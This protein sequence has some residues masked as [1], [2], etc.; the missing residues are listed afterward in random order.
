[1]LKDFDGIIV[2][3]GF[4]SR[5]IEGIVMTA[6]Y[7]R[8]NK[9]PYLGLCYGMQI[10]TIEF[11]R[12]VAK[13]PKANTQEIDPK[14][15]DPVIHIMD[16]QKDKVKKKEYGGSMR[17]GVYDCKLQK[18]TKAYEAY[19][20]EDIFERHRH[21]YEFNNDYRARF[22]KLGLVISGVNPQRNLVEIIELRNHPFF[23]GVQFHPEFKTRF[24]T[25][26]PLFYSFIKA[27]NKG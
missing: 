13:L 17:L 1:M 4:G 5:G 21:R 19:K 25:P 11:A 3:G 14:T 10:A 6:K 9:V 18:G 22:E 16:D 8:E 7:C 20:S 26:H 23:V 2:P 12:N 24:L 27:A 15:P